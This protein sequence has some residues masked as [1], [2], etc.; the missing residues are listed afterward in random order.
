MKGVVVC[1]VVDVV[2][3]DGVVVVVVVGFV[4]PGARVVTKTKISM[5]TTSTQGSIL[6]MPSSD[7]YESSVR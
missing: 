3:G 6:H 4:C 2:V 1:I 5:F 7:Q